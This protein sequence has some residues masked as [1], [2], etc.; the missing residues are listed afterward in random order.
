MK[1]ASRI[2]VIV[3][4]FLVALGS[5]FYAISGRHSLE[6]PKEGSGIAST[7]A[8]E[9]SPAK[10]T[11]RGPKDNAAHGSVAANPRVQEVLAQVTPFDD[12]M[13]RWRRGE[14]QKTAFISEGT[15]LAR[16]RRAALKELIALDPKTA[17]EHAVPRGLRN[18][19]PEAVQQEL[20]TQIDAYGKYQLLVACSEKS[21][22][23]QRRTQVNGKW[24]D[25]Y[26]YDKRLETLSKDRLAIHGIAID[27]RLALLDQP[28]RLLDSEEYAAAQIDP[29]STLAIETG[30]ST[31]TFSTFRELQKWVEAVALAEQVPGPETLNGEPVAVAADAS[32]VNGE[33]SVLWMV[34]EFSD[35]PGAPFTTQEITDCMASVNTFYKDVSRNKTSFKTNILP[36]TVKASKTKAVYETQTSAEQ[37]IGEEALAAAKAYDAAN[38]ATGAY[39]PGKN[40]RWIVIVKRITSFTSNAGGLGA[41]GGKGL[42]LNGTLGG[43]VP[44]ELGH[45]QGLSH[46]HAWV[47]AGASPIAEG[48]NNEY[49]DQFDV[50]GNCWNYP[51]GTFAHFNTKQKSNLAYLDSSEIQLVSKAGTYR[52]YRSDSRNAKN[53]QV[54]QIVPGTAYDYWIEARQLSP[55]NAA[56]DLQQRLKNGVLIHWG[57]S[58]SYTAA[59]NGSYLL[60]MTPGTSGGMN[61]APLAAGTTFIDPDYGLSVTPIASG[62]EEPSQWVDVAVT[63]GATGN[64]HNPV[65]NSLSVPIGSL[66]AHAN[67]TFS[68]SATDEDGDP[69]S[70]HWD[71]GD[72]QTNPKTATVVHRWLKGGKYTVSANATDGRG[73][74]GTKT[75]E[76]NVEDPLLT[77][78]QRG[79]G[80]TTESINTVTYV[81][82][83]FIA[84]TGSGA[85][86]VSADGVTWNFLS[87]LK[88]QNGDVIGIT[89]TGSR[90][91]VLGRR[92]DSTDK[93]WYSVVYS[94]ADGMNWRDDSPNA[95]LTGP[96]SIAFGAGRLVVVGAKGKIMQSAD[97]VSWADVDTG[98]SQGFNDV[99]YAAGRF[100]AVGWSGTIFTSTDGIVWKNQSIVAFLDIIATAYQNGT[101]WGTCSGPGIYSSTDGETWNFHST[102]GWM[103]YAWFIAS[104]QGFLLGRDYNA[105]S[106]MITED[107]SVLDTYLVSSS[108][109][110]GYLNG[111]AEGNGTIVCVGTGGRIFQA[112]TPKV[113]APQRTTMNS[114]FVAGQTATIPTTAKGFAKLQLLVNDRVVDEKTGDNPSLSWLPLK[115]GTYKMTVRGILGN[116]TSFDTDQSVTVGLGDFTW[117]NPLPQGNYLY[118]VACAFNRWWTVGTKG[119]LL[120]SGDGSSWRVETAPTTEYMNR[121]ATDGK[122]LVLTSSGYDNIHQTSLPSIWVSADGLS[123]KA[124]TVPS[125]YSNFSWSDLTY[126]NGLWAVV[127]WNGSILTSVDGET[128]IKQSTGTTKA[129]YAIAYGNGRWIASC[130]DMTVISSPDGVTWSAP[131]LVGDTAGTG[132][133]Q[134]LAFAN[135]CW[136]GRT[137][138]NKRAASADGVAWTVDTSSANYSFMT[139]LG[140]QFVATDYS[141][142]VFSSADGTTWSQQGKTGSL[143]P[144]AMEYANGVY[145]AVGNSG[146]IYSGKSL[147]SLS[148]ITLSER[149]TINALLPLSDRT[150]QGSDSYDY[151][152]GK[153]ANVLSVRNSDGTM[154]NLTIAPS[155]SYS[156]RGLVQGTGAYVAVGEH[157]SILVSTDTTTWVSQASGVTSLL[158]SAAYGMGVYVCV[159]DG[160]T[161][162]SSPDAKTWTLR[163]SS[164]TSKLS[165]VTFGNGMFIAV[166]DVGTVLTSKDGL[167]WKAQT[168]TS[169]ASLKRVVWQSG[170]GFAVIG[171]SSSSSSVVLISSE[172]GELWTAEQTIPNISWAYDLVSTQL[173]LIVIGNSASVTSDGGKH[174]LAYALPD[175]VTCAAFNNGVLWV[176]GRCGNLASQTLGV[177][178]VAIA[179]QPHAAVLMLN[180]SLSLS[181]EAI[182]TG[183]LSYQ[184]YRDGIAIIGATSAQYAKDSATSA[185]AGVYTVVIT[186]TSGGKI[187]SAG[188]EVVVNGPTVIRKSPAGVTIKA[189]EML[190]ISVEA[191]GSGTLSYQWYK[192]GV[193]I[194]GATS[195]QY[196]KTA[197][198]STDAGV[199]TV[200]VTSTTGS[201]VTSAGAEVVVNKLTTISKSPAGVTIKVGETLTISVE[202]AGS[203]TLSYQWY[204]DGVAIPGATSAQ[205]AKTAATSTDAGVYTVLVASTTGSA[206]TSA[207][208]EVVVNKLTAISKPPAGVTIKVGETL[209]I[210]VEAAGSGTLSYQWYKDGVAIPGATSAQYTKTA[211]ASTDT[212][213]YTVIATG[214]GGS[215][216]SAPATVSIQAGGR[217]AAL[218]V[219]TESGPGADVLIVGIIVSGVSDS[220]RKSVVIRG[221]GPSLAKD[222][223]PNYM[224]DPTM[225]LYEGS[226][227][228][229]END[230]WD[231][232][233]VLA[234][235]TRMHLNDLIPGS[236]DAVLLSDFANGAYTVHLGAKTEERG[237]ALAEVYECSGSG[238]A[239]LSALAARAKAGK[240]EMTLIGGFVI[241]GQGSCRL[242]IRGLGPALSADLKTGYLED[243]KLTLYSGSDV[244][245][246]N[247]NW[248]NTEELRTAI[249][250]IGM[251]PLLADSKDA[252]MVVVLPPGPYTVHLTGA[253]EAT[254]V[255][256]IEI[257]ELP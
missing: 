159:G 161:I 17:L 166:G 193:A 84:S 241:G 96:T 223:V 71:F 235:L 256:L 23:Y 91:V 131:S 22:T 98:I 206:V 95:K 81:N 244:I 21:S 54:L 86:L 51:S 209:T 35:D 116:G 168:S 215:V 123:W 75:V 228:I 151:T 70:Y 246:T 134:S 145:V 130:S 195:A 15:G 99:K 198:T 176:A 50:M 125:A 120:S 79:A 58:P 186:S 189:G 8:S 136:L 42:W 26:T 47:P 135:N 141:G 162:L 245:K 179:V 124:A 252:A 62:G 14:A 82:N 85:L 87:G 37:A 249:A 72:T 220:S 77:W 213:N 32:W 240:D 28:Y 128:W 172:N 180:Q 59:G 250:S 236:K 100:V 115:F 167:S 200:L 184:W 13:L 170:L 45:N 64:N 103:A 226:E 201:T 152:Q 111:L 224:I 175:N 56:T 78:T 121:I 191:A 203:G 204:K 211:A 57:K 24:Y 1:K 66:K 34:V 138:N 239:R 113:I 12:W 157:G 230:D 4:L 140:N 39:D 83:R 60:D 185:D 126:A 27:D 16:K 251:T 129:I 89:Y 119:V 147:S 117:L 30:N 127:G 41:V 207:G 97:G 52:L 197:A 44:H 122:K 33:K 205:Y 149:K 196:T 177:F 156:M 102:S 93:Q 40:D 181:V 202:A 164:V 248:G 242:I 173:G 114:N 212:G 243:P 11:A 6:S 137:S 5:L 92:Y 76:V 234:E 118:S 132:Y 69:I 232:G 257:Y 150:I 165:S 7:N 217:L 105:D 110:T 174:W 94:S 178:N 139:G 104:E 61:D 214:L 38:G 154:A 188:A 227:Q 73:G 183:E 153:T 253:N 10:G 210:S 190:T 187:T 36:V 169:T 208:A 29:K 143:Y 106:L 49:G 146:A 55:D 247:D 221:L 25:T 2:G 18:L 53:T 31:K 194:P 112:G 171:A 218:A 222:K 19:L 192:D 255:A 90:Y 109:G 163:T 142:T 231:S 225:R 88:S 48:T 133:L 9:R 158:S 80:L 43:A 238:S 65:L 68:A 199:Y 144:S 182:G 216:E 67:I 229:G 63:F 148:S 74:M 160:G 254:G 108:G 46:S 3:A 20:E 107:G 237:V 219:R 233:A 101:W 155:V